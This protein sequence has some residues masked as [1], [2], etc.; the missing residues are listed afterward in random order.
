M[1]TSK[2]SKSIGLAWSLQFASELLVALQVQVNR[3]FN[4][5][6]ITE[7]VLVLLDL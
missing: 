3:C 7:C 4:T 6:E 5:L 1:R 2:D